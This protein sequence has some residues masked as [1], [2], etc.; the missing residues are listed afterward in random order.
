MGIR[1]VS[2]ES[3][4]PQY[5]HRDS[6]SPLH[7]QFTPRRL[8]APLHSGLSK[9][10]SSDSQRLCQDG[11]ALSLRIPSGFSVRSTG[12]LRASSERES[13]PCLTVSLKLWLH[14]CSRSSS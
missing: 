11:A 13:L 4:K 7:Q 10:S 14:S 1:P 2:R 9:P 5:S 3:V 12:G 8:P 6:H